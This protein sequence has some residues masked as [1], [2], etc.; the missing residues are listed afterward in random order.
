MKC[1]YC[2]QETPDDSTRCRYCGKWLDKT[3][4][5]KIAF[6]DSRV[7]RSTLS[8]NSESLI[9]RHIEEWKQKLIDLTRR[10]RLIYFKQT[11]SSTLIISHPE[12]QTVFEQLV[13]NEAEWEF[14]FP[15][16]EEET[17]ERSTSDLLVPSEKEQGSQFQLTFLHEEISDEESQEI[18]EPIEETSSPFKSPKKNE[19]LTEGLDRE[20]LER[21]IK[22]LY[23]RSSSDYKERGVRI[24]YLVLGM[25]RWKEDNSSEVIRSPLVLVPVELR[26]ESAREPFRL[27]P[28]DEDPVLNPALHVKLRRD[29][30]IE[31][32]PFPDDWEGF[33]IHTY[34]DS[35]TEAGGKLGWSVEPTVLI[36]LFSFYKIVMHQDLEVNEPVIS[37]HPLISALAEE[38]PQEGIVI[39]SPIDE[40]QLDSIQESD[41]MFH[42]LDADSS[43]QVCIELAHQ[44]QS[45]VLH[46]PPGTGKS[47]TISNII[48]AFIA[49]GKTVLFVSEKMAA[50]EVV[51]KRLH[52]AELDD[53][54][55]ELHSYKANKREVIKELNRS[56]EEQV[57]PKKSISNIEFE[58]LLHLREKLNNYVISLHRIREPLGESVFS[59]LGKLVSLERVPFVTVEIPNL[60]GLTSRRILEFEELVLQMKNVWQVAQEGKN[61][62]WHGYRESRFTRDYLGVLN[63][64]LATYFIKVI[65][66]NLTKGSFTKVRTNQL[67]KLPIRTINFNNTSEKKLHDNLVTLVDVMLNLNNTNLTAKG[68]EKEQI[69]RQIEKT[70]REIDEIVYK[71][72]GITEEERKIIE[73]KE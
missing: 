40:L 19:L 3:S 9:K 58:R 57:V 30:K 18:D 64:K 43:Q 4:E 21:I 35:V 1:P 52:E 11:K 67:A 62:P 73:S 25:L 72:Y 17:S 50:L 42:I 49:S 24:L 14:W 63:S 10:N 34:F 31:L 8:I 15:P 69:Q 46:G 59:V 39:G 32:P 23:R 41:R 29:F 7:E 6:Q 56:L 26:R 13:M 45:F 47:Q 33:N 68:N 55:L 5:S 66:F 65:A 53:F 20:E 36:G 12:P 37:K 54:C 71:L 44:G 16:V 27:F 28:V 38:P 22:N 48:A 51:F 2:A 70:D 60:D 61:F